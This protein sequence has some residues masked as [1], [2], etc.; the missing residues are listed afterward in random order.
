MV[1]CTEPP[2][3]V[4]QA[5]VAALGDICTSVICLFS[6]SYLP[7]V[8]ILKLRAEECNQLF[9]GNTG[10]L[11]SYVCFECRSASKGRAAF[12]IEEN[13]ALWQSESFKRTHIP[14]C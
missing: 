8:I 12:F 5:T 9:S 7:I 1:K 3:S 14:I 6:A 11:Q 4:S 10:A 13:S 2:H